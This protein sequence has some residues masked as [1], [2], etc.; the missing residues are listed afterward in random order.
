[1]GFQSFGM[2]RGPPVD[3]VGGGGLNLTGGSPLVHVLSASAVDEI[4]H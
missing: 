2:E 4:E 3:K 1:M